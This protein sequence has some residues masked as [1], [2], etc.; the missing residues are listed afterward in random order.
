MSVYSNLFHF[1][2]NLETTPS[3]L[4]GEQIIKFCYFYGIL[5]SNKREKVTNTCNNMEKIQKHYT[6]QKDSDVKNAC[7]SN[8]MKFQKA[9]IIYN[10]QEQTNS[11]LRLREGRRKTT[12][13][14]LQCKP[15]LALANHEL[16]LGNLNLRKWCGDGRV[17]ENLVTP[18]MTH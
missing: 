4:V 8:Y 11:Y 3:P 6:V 16:P 12:L 17:V 1:G 14:Q 2:K 18:A 13:Q 10:D 5:L 9:K 7:D 15:A